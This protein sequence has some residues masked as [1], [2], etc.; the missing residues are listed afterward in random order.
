MLTCKQ[1]TEL[2][3]KKLDTSLPWHTHIQIKVHLL[4]CKTCAKYEK[5]MKFIDEISKKIDFHYQGYAL[6]KEAK[7]RIKENLKSYTENKGS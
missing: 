3:S 4:I 6:S 2:S 5:Q 1:I 7:K